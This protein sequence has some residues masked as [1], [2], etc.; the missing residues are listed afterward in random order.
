MNDGIDFSV[1]GFDE[2]STKLGDFRRRLQDMNVSPSL[3]LFAAKV[4]IRSCFDTI[5]HQTLLKEAV[6]F[7]SSSG[8]KIFR[9]AS[10]RLLSSNRFK[11]TF[12]KNVIPHSSATNAN[13]WLQFT[14]GL[15][16]HTVVVQ[17]PNFGPSFLE[18]P[19]LSSLLKRHIR[20]HLVYVNGDGYYK[21]LVGIPQGSVLSSL[22]CRYSFHYMVSIYYA[23]LDKTE[24]G[25][26]KRPDTVQFLYVAEPITS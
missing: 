16:P 3:Q 20:Q 22:L 12:H 23:D 15:R 8:Y 26:F 9:W 5:C 13:E 1:L 19:K 14:N 11:R 4:D 10:I 7:S 17:Q 2:M 24:L 6:K 25:E 18:T 21:Q